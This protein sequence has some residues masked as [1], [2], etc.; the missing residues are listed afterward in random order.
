MQQAKAQE[1]QTWFLSELLKL[2]VVE[3][4]GGILGRVADLVVDARGFA[5]PVT[6]LVVANGY[7]ARQFLPW[8]AVESLEPKFVRA[9][10]GAAAQL[11]PLDERHGQ[12]LLGEHIFDRQIV[13]TGGAKVVRV[14]DLL[15]RRRGKGLILSKVDVGLRGLLRRVGLQGVTEA[16]LRFI[17]SYNLGD[18]LINWN[19]VQPVGSNDILQ[20]K[21]SQNRLSR[22][23]PA[24]LADII[25]DLDGPARERVF[26]ALAVDLVA[27]VLEETDPKVQVAL[28][29][30]MPDEQAS[31][32]LEQMSPDEAA[33]ILQNMDAKRARTI[34]QDMEHEQAAHVACLLDHDEE[35]AG[36]LMTT[37]FLSLP[38]DQTVERALDLLRQKSEDL[39]VI[40]YVYVEDADGHLLGVVSLREL[41]NSNPKA[42]L[43]SIMF[44]RLVAVQLED[45]QD[46]VAELFAKYGLRAIPVLDK[47]GRLHGVLRFKAL[48]E[49]VAPHLGR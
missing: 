32:I 6:G 41:F 13:D 5:P 47:Q 9:I 26:K 4:Q 23:H 43:G 38:P 45:E 21:I 1:E 37:E 12:M 10:P 39:D 7:K 48:L 25:E 8:S 29:R 40:Y 30:N 20:L 22:L 3:P 31:D 36:G 15:L 2:R 14:N 42:T 49:A 46:D 35:T 16:M 18:N 33:D 24:D 27:E 44:T 17:F 34:L 28:I 19:L 11:I